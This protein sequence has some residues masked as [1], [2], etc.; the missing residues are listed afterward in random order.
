MLHCAPVRPVVTVAG[1]DRALGTLQVPLLSWA[2][3][4]PAIG[5]GVQHV[6]KEAAVPFAYLAFG[7]AGMQFFLMDRDGA[8]SQEP[9]LLRLTRD[10]P[11][12]VGGGLSHVCL[13]CHGGVCWKCA[14]M[15]HAF[16]RQLCEATA[17]E[18][19]METWQLRCG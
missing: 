11:V 19:H 15:W 6:L 12:E 13:V 1:P 4:M 7:R 17:A 14:P 18:A 5:G 2:G 10:H 3:A 8:G 16:F 9:L